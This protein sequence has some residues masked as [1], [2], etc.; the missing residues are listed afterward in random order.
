MLLQINNI[1]IIIKSSHYFYFLDKLTRY[2]SLISSRFSL[3]KNITK[4][5]T[6]TQIVPVHLPLSRPVISRKL[7]QNILDQQIH[8]VDIFV[9]DSD[10]VLTM[11][12]KF[13]KNCLEHEVH[14]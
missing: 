5:K 7:F 1:F 2:Y 3:L 14:F 6:G 8:V 10:V 12:R 11:G 9:T 13:L 4:K